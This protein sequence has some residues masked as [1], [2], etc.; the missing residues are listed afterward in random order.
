MAVGFQQH[1]QGV[2][3]VLIVINDEEGWRVRFHKG[4]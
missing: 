3:I 1:L 4:L 2:S